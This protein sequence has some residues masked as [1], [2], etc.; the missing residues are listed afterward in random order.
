VR[1]G[2]STIC[3]VDEWIRRLPGEIGYEAAGASLILIMGWAY[4]HRNKLVRREPIHIS[5]ASGGASGASA[6]AVVLEGVGTDELVGTLTVT[7]HDPPPSA[8]EELF[9][10]YMRVR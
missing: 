8:I 2:S 5:G 7:R 10:W 1:A 4:K 3:T 6:S 9:W